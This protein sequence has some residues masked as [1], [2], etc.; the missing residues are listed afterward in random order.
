MGIVLTSEE[1]ETIAPIVRPCFAAV[2]LTNDYYSFDVEWEEFQETYRTEGSHTMTNAVWLYMNWENLS[3]DEAKSRVVQVV[4][5][6][7]KEFQRS[8][9]GFIADTNR[10]G[11]HLREYLRS[12][13]FQMPGNIAWSLRCPRYH[14][15]LCFEATKLLH[16]DADQDQLLPGR[17][18]EPLDDE[19]SD[20]NSSV[21]STS[22]GKTSNSIPSNRSSVDLPDDLSH[23]PETKSRPQLGS[24]VCDLSQIDQIERYADSTTFLA[25]T[26]PL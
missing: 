6:Y 20:T 4:R 1:E 23:D 22:G 17:K 16:A 18:Q 10:C 26:R 9:N 8:A 7:E 19:D 14:P 15:E 25:S 5:G 3:I 2:G 12:M 11:P 13:A 21:G 24:E